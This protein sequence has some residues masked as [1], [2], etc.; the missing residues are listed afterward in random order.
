MEQC[1][2]GRLIDID[3]D[4]N[5]QCEQTVNAYETLTCDD[6][7]VGCTQIGTALQCAPV[8]TRCWPGADSCCWVTVT[9][10]AGVS[11][12]VRGGDCCGYTYTKTITSVTEFLSGV[13]YDV[14][15]SKITCNNTGRCTMSFENAYCNNPSVSIGHYDN[16]N[17]FNMTTRPTWA[18][19]TGGGCEALDARTQ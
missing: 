6:S 16:V 4:A 13:P 9:C 10:N 2:M 8:S 12:T 15:G 3:T 18:C 7:S 19:S 1:A 14:A 11:V 5:F 17:S